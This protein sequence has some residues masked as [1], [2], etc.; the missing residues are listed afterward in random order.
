MENR[1]RLKAFSKLN[2][3]QITCRGGAD[4][5]WINYQDY[6]YWLQAQ[7][8]IQIG[9]VLNA[10]RSRPEISE[11]TIVIFT[12]DHGDHVGSHGLHEKALTVYEE[13]IHLPLLVYDPTGH[14]TRAEGTPREQFT[15]TID[16]SPLFLTLATG[17]RTWLR[18]PRFNFLSHQADWES[19][20]PRKVNSCCE[21]ASAPKIPGAAT[22][23]K[24]VPIPLIAWRR[25]IGFCLL[26]RKDTLAFLSSSWLTQAKTP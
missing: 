1:S 21:L 13:S 6:Y 7:V 8:D 16:L 23:T 22:A 12:A 2:I 18:D 14:W 5:G 24:P 17:G 11:N 10:L 20:L 19:L 3:I 9:N 25:L 26:I 15:S 4:T